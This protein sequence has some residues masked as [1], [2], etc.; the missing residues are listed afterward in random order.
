MKKTTSLLFILLTLSAFC[1]K[2]MSQSVENKTL[3]GS[4]NQQI[5][6]INTATRPAADKQASMQGGQ[7]TGASNNTRQS[8]RQSRRQ[9][10]RQ[11]V[12]KAIH[13]AR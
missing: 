6:T 13:A 11:T 7:P 1:I 2:G 10:R 3:T 12:V 4:Y 8:R 9:T 5:S